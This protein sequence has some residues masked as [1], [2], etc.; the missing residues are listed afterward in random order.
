M[1]M[2]DDN[3]QTTEFTFELKN[4][5]QSLCLFLT[6]VCCGIIATILFQHFG[7]R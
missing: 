4:P 5:W 2:R 7:G 6:G 3:W 1:T